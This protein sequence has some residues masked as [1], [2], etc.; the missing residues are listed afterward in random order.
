MKFTHNFFLPVTQ[1]LLFRYSPWTNKAKKSTIP[2][3]RRRIPARMWLEGVNLNAAVE[4]AERKR[5]RRVVPEK[6]IGGTSSR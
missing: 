5:K 1:R 6:P 4:L 3:T 2:T